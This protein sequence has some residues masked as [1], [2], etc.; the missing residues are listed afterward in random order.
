M[1][2]PL[3][4]GMSAMRKKARDA[5]VAASDR[6]PRLRIAG[7]MFA[8]AALVTL[9]GNAAAQVVYCVPCVDHRWEEMGQML[10]NRAENL[11]TARA[12]LRT[13]Q[14]QGS[15]LD[16]NEAK[17]LLEE[18]SAEWDEAY[19]SA[20]VLGV[21]SYSSYLARNLVEVEAS[22]DGALAELQ[23]KTEQYD[24][25]RSALGD[26]RTRVAAD[27]AGTEKEE[28]GLVRGMALEAGLNAMKAAS[29][30]AAEAVRAIELGTNGARG[31]AAQVRSLKRL[32]ELN[33][34]VEV[35]K[36]NAELA[37]EEYLKSATSFAQIV[38][39]PIAL[40]YAPALLP[41]AILV[42][43]IA[44]LT[45]DL[46]AVGLNQIQ[47]EEAKSRLAGIADQEFHWQSEIH[48]LTARAANLKLE[49]EMASHS[50]ARQDAF[51]RQLS[52]IQSELAPVE[53]AP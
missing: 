2:C 25:L 40:T 19:A 30:H 45:L 29:L 10:A 24:R 20:K 42:G 41:A 17:Q 14:Q 22:Y 53:I 32:V 23:S 27:L 43:P 7:V 44:T 51:G 15:Q 13:I 9:H 39:E 11:K 5:S 12:Y 4:K 34:Q 46:A 38:L 1:V 3:R 26:Q 18:A 37:S 8:L 35:G 28:L 47:Q 52:A 31:S 6:N 16:I 33:N 36:A 21:P 50:I 48:R 49:S